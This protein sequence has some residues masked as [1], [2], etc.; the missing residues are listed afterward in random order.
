[1]RK[2]F[3]SALILSSVAAAAPAAAQHR[4]YDRGYDQRYA[5][6][7]DQRSDRGYGYANRHGLPG[8]GI[9]RELR[10]VEN[11]I[12]RL[13]DRRMISRD[14]ARRLSYRAARIDERV[15]HYVRGGLRRYEQR[16]LL[17]RVAELRRDVRAERLEG[18]Y[19]QRHRGW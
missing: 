18:R 9:K 11:Q 14:E 10:Q 4:G 8:D 7:Y 6:G 3:L 13:H 19:A 16:E 15:D 12:A 2:L 17:Q 5:R 1:M